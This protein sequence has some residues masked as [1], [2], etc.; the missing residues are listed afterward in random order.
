MSFGTGSKDLYF[1][2]TDASGNSGCNETNPVIATSVA[3]FI[4]AN[5][6]TQV[7]KGPKTVS[8]PFLFARGGKTTN[9]CS[10]VGTTEQ[11]KSQTDISIFPNPGTGKFNFELGNELNQSRTIE[12]YNVLGEEVYSGAEQISN[13]IIDIKY[14]TQLK[15]LANMDKENA[16]RFWWRACY[17]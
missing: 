11:N 15:K 2:K 9:L 10:T 8:Y 6:A 17:Y 16:T 3:P 4:Q 13:F 12:I 1:V 7:T 5:A 14:Y